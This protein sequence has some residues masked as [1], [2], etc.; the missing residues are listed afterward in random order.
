ME[1]AH[2]NKLQRQQTK[3]R[4]E[5]NLDNEPSLEMPAETVMWRLIAFAFPFSLD[6]IQSHSICLFQIRRI[7][8]YNV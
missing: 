3:L 4:R 5:L 8:F 6:C 1:R 2:Q 7:F